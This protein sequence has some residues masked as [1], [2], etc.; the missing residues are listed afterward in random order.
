MNKTT[1]SIRTFDKYPKRARKA[2]ADGPVFVSERGRHAYALLTIEE[3]RRIGGDAASLLARLAMPGVGD[4][5]F[6]PP[7]MGDEPIQAVDFS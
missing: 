7:R 4:I 1:I 6:D 3:Y 5:D 2:A